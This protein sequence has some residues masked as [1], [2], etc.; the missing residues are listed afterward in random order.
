[1]KPMAFTPAYGD[2]FLPTYLVLFK[3]F[4]QEQPV[5]VF[6]IVKFLLTKVLA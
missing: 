2:S 3:D 5:K 1:M 6:T 4:P